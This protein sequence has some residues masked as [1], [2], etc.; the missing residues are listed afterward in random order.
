MKNKKYKAA[1]I[2]CGR[3]GVEAGLFKKEVQPAT[4][5]GAYK[6]HARIE[7]AGLVDIN[8]ERLK[9]AAR[10]FP[11]VPLFESSK[12]MLVKLKPDI[13]SIATH[14]DS[15]LE[16]IKL[17]SNYRTPAIVCEKPMAGTLEEAGEIIDLCKKSGSLLFI[18]HVRRFDSCLRKIK[19][20]IKGGKIGELIQGTYYYENGI[21]NNGTHLVDLLRF[22]IGEI[23]WVMGIQ[24]KKTKNKNLKKDLNIDGFLHFK[25][26]TM[27]NI[28]SFPFKYGIS[29]MYLFGSKGAIFLKNLGYKVEYKKLIKNKFFKG[30]SQLSE[31]MESFGKIRSF[32]APMV[33]HVVKCLDGKEKPISTGR[34]GLEALK[35]LF[36]LKESSKNNSRIVKIN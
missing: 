27:V 5:A 36:A 32:M 17:V 12:E 2:G 34:D 7:L 20:D 35:V 18:N 29:E 28:Q 24:N 19:Q 26:G 30:Y 16:L 3:I 31:N 25:N 21:F 33:E 1:V 13:I 4:H 11:G 8:P 10:Y 23:D 22:F 9:M 14:V 15:H 6:T